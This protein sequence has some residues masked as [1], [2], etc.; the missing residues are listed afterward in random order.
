M[1]LFKEPGQ[2][3]TSFRRCSCGIFI[4]LLVNCCIVHA[5]TIK[6]YSTAVFYGADLPLEMLAK[7]QRVI[8]EPDNTTVEELTFL[9]KK[10]VSV[11]AYLSIG[12]VG[13]ARTWSSQLD[14]TWTLGV[15]K[16]W[17]SA[18]MDLNSKGWRDYLIEQRMESLWQKGFRG[19]FLD[20]MDSY[21]LI[22]KTP[23]ALKLQKQGMVKLIRKISSEFSGVYLIF[24]RGFEVLDEVANLADGL[25][26]ESL[27]AGWNPTTSSYREVTPKD[28]KWLL[29]KL[30][31]VRDKYGLPIIVIDYLPPGKRKRARQVAKQITDLGFTPWVSTPQ[32]NEMGL[33]IPEKAGF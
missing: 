27:F 11:Y 26:V 12:E 7:Y 30:G 31:M 22:A 33:G 24:N 23:S 1:K 2:N 16:G 10:G 9:K 14:K 18:V 32:L 3:L 5:K 15:N 19:F 21:Q 17:N 8:L 13:S 25:V 29:N 4:A 6:Q 20:T 28:R